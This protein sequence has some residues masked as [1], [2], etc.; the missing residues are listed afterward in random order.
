MLRYDINTNTFVKKWNKK[1][2]LVLDL[3]KEMIPSSEC[4]EV[5]QAFEENADGFIDDND[6]R[7]TKS[8]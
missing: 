7:N 3:D 6:V 5:P 2:V 4:Q 1:V 8:N